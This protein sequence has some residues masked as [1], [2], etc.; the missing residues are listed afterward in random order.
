MSLNMKNISIAFHFDL[1]DIEK[2][3]MIKGNNLYTLVCHFGYEEIPHDMSKYESY[4]IH[5]KDGKTIT[6]R[7]IQNRIKMMNRVLNEYHTLISEAKPS[8][9]LNE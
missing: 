5:L 2:I 6:K 4:T 8:D 9:K 3:T 1:K 7:D